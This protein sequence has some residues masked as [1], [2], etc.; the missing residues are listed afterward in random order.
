MHIVS[1]AGLNTQTV[2]A[3]HIPLPPLLCCHNRVTPF[4]HTGHPVFAMHPRGVGLINVHASMLLCRSDRRGRGATLAPILQL[5]FTV[6]MTWR[7]ERCWAAQ[8]KAHAGSG[9]PATGL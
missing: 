7:M 3:D 4:I 8:H 2:T 9:T 5:L 1:A 6:G